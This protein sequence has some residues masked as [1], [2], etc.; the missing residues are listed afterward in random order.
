MYECE[1]SV[2]NVRAPIVNTAA[3]EVLGPNPARVA[4]I[5]SPHYSEEFTIATDPR[6][7][8]GAGIVMAITATPIVLTRQQLGRAITLPF[9][10]ISAANAVTI[11]IQEFT[12]IPGPP[13][14]REKPYG[15]RP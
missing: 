3:S 6:V 4:V 5:I 1:S 2:N 8:R 7:V 14:E 10:A 11:G 9:F 13:H 15:R 12:E